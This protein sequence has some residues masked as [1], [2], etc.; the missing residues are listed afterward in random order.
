[1]FITSEKLKNWF[2]RSKVD[3]FYISLLSCVCGGLQF[4]VNIMKTTKIKA[5]NK[6]Q[7]N[8]TYIHQIRVR[9]ISLP[10]SNIN[11]FS[12]VHGWF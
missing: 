10:F 12:C 7:Q 4:V 9:L 2:R 6:Y 5:Y 8:K 11:S 1:M 3:D